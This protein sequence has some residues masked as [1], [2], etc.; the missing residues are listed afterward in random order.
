M[1][2]VPVSAALRWAVS[3]RTR[4]RGVF[5]RAVSVPAVSVPARSGPARSGPAVSADWSEEIWSELICSEL[6]RFGVGV[7]ADGRSAASSSEVASS[8]SRSAAS[9]ASSPSAVRTAAVVW[10][11]WSR[12][13]GGDHR[14]DRVAHRFGRAEQPGRLERVALRERERREIFEHAGHPPPVAQLAVHLEAAAQQRDGGRI[15]VDGGEQA[16]LLHRPGDALLEADPLRQGKAIGQQ[17]GRPFTVAYLEGDWTVF[18][19]QA[20]CYDDKVEILTADGWKLIPKVNVGEPVATLAPD[21]EMT[22]EPVT[23]VWEF[24]YSGDMY[25]HEGRALDFSVTP[26]HR[27]WTHCRNSPADFRFTAVEDLPDQSVH[28]RAAGT[29]RGEEADTV[30]IRSPWNAEPDFAPPPGMCV[31]CGKKPPQRY[32]R[33]RCEPCYRAWMRMGQPDDLSLV[34]ERR[35]NYVEHRAQRKEY[36]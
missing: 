22:F 13:D 36:T 30:T 28:L 11:C 24:P 35:A 1:R 16:E 7:W 31:I 32:R 6:D 34:R 9:N 12:S 15:T 27:M 26:G 8:P 3:A 18:A 33:G 25:V 4:G 2:S 29:W 17:C 14:P 5:C 10:L 21:G 19:G 20:F 23:A